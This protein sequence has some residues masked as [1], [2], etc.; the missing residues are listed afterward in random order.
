MDKEKIKEL[1]KYSDIERVIENAKRYLGNDVEIY[2]ATHPKS[3]FMV[4]DPVK[5]KFV[6]FG[7]MGYQDYTKHQDEKRRQGY[8]KRANAIKG[9]W[10]NNKYSKNNLAINILWL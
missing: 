1:Q 7:A 6:E 2:P 4:F 3:K 5:Y 10:K 8:L 9:D